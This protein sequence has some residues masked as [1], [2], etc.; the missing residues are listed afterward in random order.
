MAKGNDGSLIRPLPSRRLSP[1]QPPAGAH[2]EPG[3]HHRV[4]G[5]HPLDCGEGSPP[6]GIGPL[7]SIVSSRRPF[8]S[9]GRPKE[10]RWRD[11]SA[12]P[13]SEFGSPPVK[14]LTASFRNVLLVPSASA[15][16]SVVVGTVVT[17]R[18]HL[19]LTTG[20]PLPLGVLR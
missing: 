1:L 17:V 18:N 9:R 6:C 19:L 15:A 5:S 13:L 8:V 20:R 11:H 2:S 14:N 10:E 7:P 3:G 12:S 4:C 16:A